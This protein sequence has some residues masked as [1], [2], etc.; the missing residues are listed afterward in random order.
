MKSCTV[1]MLVIAVVQPCLAGISD[2]SWYG[3]RDL[4]AKLNSFDHGPASAAEFTT[5]DLFDMVATGDVNDALAA[6]G[7]LTRDWDAVTE[8]FDRLMAL[9]QQD[10]GALKV[11]RKTGAAGDARGLPEYRTRGDPILYRLAETVREGPL[12]PQRTALTLRLMAHLERIVKGDP[13]PIPRHMALSTFVKC[14]FYPNGLIRPAADT[15]CVKKLLVD[16]L[17]DPDFR[18]RMCAIYGLGEIAGVY[19]EVLP[20]IEERYEVELNAS[21]AGEPGREDALDSMRWLLMGLEPY[22]KW[23]CGTIPEQTVRAMP[24]MTSSQLMEMFS[25][26][27]PASWF[28]IK[29]IMKTEERREACIPALLEIAN[30]DTRFF[31][32]ILGG[33]PD[34]IPEFASAADKAWMEQ[35][36][37]FLE[38]CVAEEPHR[39]A[40]R[41]AIKK[42]MFLARD[43]TGARHVRERA[44]SD[45]VDL[46]AHPDSEVQS[47]ALSYVRSVVRQSPELLEFARGRLEQRQAGL[48][49][50]NRLDLA[51]KPARRPYPPEWEVYIGIEDILVPPETRVRSGYPT[52]EDLAI[53][54]ARRKAEEEA[55][56]LMREREHKD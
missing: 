23:R 44:L 40:R 38:R 10:L 45:L 43:S 13:S 36:L 30:D 37:V 7:R 9:S 29:T 15:E 35:F 49:K 32:T 11:D 56:R 54:A 21:D 28:A 24:S 31:E 6:L 47:K 25:K 12:G 1:A 33:V 18:V 26:G 52:P 41:M 4:D 14:V 20:L 42:L 2:R 53:E 3:Y 50:E 8:H 16:S 34:A 19:R 39:G 46:L 17:D 51:D 27:P 5:D 22:E 55:M 48:L